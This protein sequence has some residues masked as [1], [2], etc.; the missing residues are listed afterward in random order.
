VA[1]SAIQVTVATMEPVINVEAAV[2]RPSADP[3]TRS[4][5]LSMRRHKRWI[6]FGNAFPSNV[7]RS[8]L[9]GSGNPPDPALKSFT[10]ASSSWS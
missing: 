9:R 3:N 10:P 4:A 1:A 5:D 6:A 7:I 2:Q 8:C